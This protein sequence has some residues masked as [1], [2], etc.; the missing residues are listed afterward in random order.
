MEMVAQVE[1]NGLYIHDLNHKQSRQ[2]LNQI[3]QAKGHCL[4]RWPKKEACRLSS[5]AL[6]TESKTTSNLPVPRAA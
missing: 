1:W 3:S 4:T 5:S 6:G 2:A